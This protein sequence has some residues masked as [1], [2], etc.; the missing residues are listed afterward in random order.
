MGPKGDGIGAGQVAGRRAGRRGRN[1]HYAFDKT[2]PLPHNSS[3]MDAAS[4]DALDALF[5]EVYD[6]LRKMARGLLCT[7]PPNRTLQPT[8]LVH[9]AYLRLSHT[10]RKD[11]V[12]RPYFFGAAA[13][14]MRR[15]LIE[16]ARRKM[17]L[18]RGGNWARVP[19]EDVRVAT[20]APPKLLLGIDEALGR[21]ATH[22]PLRAE[23]VRLMFFAG[24]TQA[25][26]GE[27]LNI[28]ERTVKRHWAC[29]RSWLYEE[30]NED[31]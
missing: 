8:V 26:A 9:E 5:G 24:L 23:V 15:I 2:L 10:Y 13:K 16:D 31:S 21:L 18:K 11:A 28:S 19:L 27:C 1:I 29:A 25:E 7:S 12:S 3:V 17:R 22:H 20:D 30:L 4:P 14:A 6:E